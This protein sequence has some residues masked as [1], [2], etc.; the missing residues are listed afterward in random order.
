MTDGESAA[1]RQGKYLPEVALLAAVFIW[2]FAFIA[3]KDAL[4]QIDTLA[5]ITIRFSLML[6][7]AF[8]ILLVTRARGGEGP[9]TIARADWPLLVCA[10]LVGTT[11]N[12]VG[13]ALGIDRTSP[14][15]AAVLS[16]I[17]PVVTMVI[18]RLMGQR[19]G[20]LAWVGVLVAL[21]GVIVFLSTRNAEGMTLLGNVLL[22]VGTIAFAVYGII[23]QPIVRAY[24][25]T[26]AM[27]W[28]LA[29]GSIPLILAGIPSSLRMDWG[30]LGAGAWV[31]VLYMVIFPIYVA[32]ILWNYGIQQRGPVIA[33]SFGLLTPIVSGVLAG[34]FYGEQFGWHKIGG[35]AM[36]LAGLAVMR[37][38]MLRNAPPPGDP[39]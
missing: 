26:T 13:F 2:A 8:G 34:L 21:A 28:S 7:L 20:V 6:V 17:S 31:S 12:Q 15:A 36:V 4:D 1:G 29:V 33:S 35:A 24:P 10:A 25:Q 18:M 38:A 3:A 16:A 22:M 27:A 11:L 37:V 5:Y 14:F 23:F 39:A 32:Y 19:Q 9:F 30:S